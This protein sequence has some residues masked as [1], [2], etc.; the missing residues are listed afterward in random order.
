VLGHGSA[1]S[2]R[3]DRAFKDLGFDSLTAVELRNQLA[4]ITGVRLPATL[5]FD[6]PAPAALAA[7]LAERFAP[8]TGDE[9]EA[10][11]HDVDRLEQWLLAGPLDGDHRRMVAG[12][13]RAVLGRLDGSGHAPVDAELADTSADDLLSL[14][15]EEFGGLSR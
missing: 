10:V 14:I 2:V 5:I 13:L 11:L 8:D 12:R 15:D 4:A 7:H 3:A 9:T 6:Y 1:T